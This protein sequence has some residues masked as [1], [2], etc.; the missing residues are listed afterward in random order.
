M[1]LLLL[2]LLRYYYEYYKSQN[3]ESCEEGIVSVDESDVS[4][5][6]SV[7]SPVDITWPS[8]VAVD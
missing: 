5:V 4:P 2:L 1:L 7:G 8:W 6:S 3:W